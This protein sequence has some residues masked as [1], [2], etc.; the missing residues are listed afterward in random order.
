M[1]SL[2]LRKGAWIT[3]N[4]IYGYIEYGYALSPGPCPADRSEEEEDLDSTPNPDSRTLTGDWVF[5]NNIAVGGLIAIGIGPW[6][7]TCTSLSHF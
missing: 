6:D 7:S 3:D 1:P 2:D 4:A 5:A